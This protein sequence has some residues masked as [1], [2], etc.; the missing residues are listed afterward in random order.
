MKTSIAS[1][2]DPLLVI[3]NRKE[4]VRWLGSLANLDDWSDE[5]LEEARNFEQARPKVVNEV[6]KETL[7]VRAIVILISH[8]HYRP[9]AKFSNVCV[10]LSHVETHDFNYVLQF[11]IREDL[12][13]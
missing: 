9:I 12:R 3:R 1:L 8:N 13:C 10:G 5:F 7:N 4:A 11:L 6:D 2:I